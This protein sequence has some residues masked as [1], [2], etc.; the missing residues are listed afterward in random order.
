MDLP[1]YDTEGK[2]ITYS[3]RELS[4]NTGAESYM[5]TDDTV[6][7]TGEHAGVWNVAV[8]EPADGLVTVTNSTAKTDIN[9]LKIDTETEQPLSGAVFKLEKLNAENRYDTVEE[10]ITVGAEGDDK[11]KAVM[12]GLTDGDYRLTETKAPAGYISLAQRITFTIVNGQASFD[13]NNYAVYTPENN[14]LTIHNKAGLALPS[15]GGS[16]T[17]PYTAGGLSLILMAVLLK[18]MKKRRKNYQ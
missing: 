3:I 9:I 5:V 14:T 11:G 13:N 17:L 2:Q 7:V 16:G 6:T 15:T 18:L 12:T 1:V 10:S 4:V 8:S